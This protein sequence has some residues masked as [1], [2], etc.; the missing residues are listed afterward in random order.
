MRKQFIGANVVSLPEYQNYL[1][2]YPAIQ[3]K[4]EDL[5]DLYFVIHRIAIKR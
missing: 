2:H 4:N 5:G 3:L 1:W